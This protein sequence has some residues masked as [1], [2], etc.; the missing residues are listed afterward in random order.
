VRQ[1]EVISPMAKLADMNG[2]LAAALQEQLNILWQTAG[3]VDGSPSF[4]AGA[5]AG[6][7]DKQNYDIDKRRNSASRR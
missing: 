6:H 4:A 1:P 3:W 7:S 5:W 2:E